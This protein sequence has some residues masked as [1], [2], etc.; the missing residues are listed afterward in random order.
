MV[1][2]SS[3]CS[4]F[5]NSNIFGSCII[6]ILFIGVL[7]FKKNNS[8]AERLK[9]IYVV[10]HFVCIL[11]MCT[12]F[13]NFYPSSMS[14]STKLSLPFT[15]YEQ[16]F[17]YTTQ[18]VLLYYMSGSLHQPSL[19]SPPQIFI[20]TCE[21]KLRNSAYTMFCEK[22]DVAWQSLEQHE[23]SQEYEFSPP[24]V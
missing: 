3:K 21:K 9:Y 16:N 13:F 19:I 8:G 12:F 15:F 24:E 5:H 18:I 1:F 7:K 2:F 14:I 20:S 17:A 23:P 22:L 10:V 6:H 4:L 11:R